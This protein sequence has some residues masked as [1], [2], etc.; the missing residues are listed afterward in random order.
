MNFLTAS[1]D[2]SS[3]WRTIVRG[4]R[5]LERGMT[6]RVGGVSPVPPCRVWIAAIGCFLATACGGGGGRRALRTLPCR[7]TPLALRW[8]SSP[9]REMLRYPF[10]SIRRPRPDRA[11]SPAIRHSARLA[12]QPYR[13]Q[14]RPALWLSRSCQTGWPTHARCRPLT[15]LGPGPGRR[16]SPPLLSGRLGRPALQP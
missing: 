15:R 10:R 9:H 6:E 11:R 8:A 12:Q 14:D 7:S 3:C 16:G 2:V 13:R 1:S 4:E 5:M